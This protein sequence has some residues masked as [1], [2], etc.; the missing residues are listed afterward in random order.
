MEGGKVFN[1]RE[2]K[3]LPCLPLRRTLSFAH[4]ELLN[5]IKDFHS[6][7]DPVK[8]LDVL[9]TGV[10]LVL[11]KD[12]P[13]EKA[14]ESVKRIKENTVDWNEARV[15]SLYE[16]MEWLKP[17]G[18][19]NLEEKC[20]R[21]KQFLVSVYREINEMDLDWLSDTQPEERG[22][23][24]SKLDMLEPWMI[25]YLQCAAEDFNCF[26]FQSDLNRVLHRTGILGKE[27]TLK[28]ASQA[29]KEMFEGMK[30]KFLW[31]CSLVK[32]GTE[33]CISS[34]RVSACRKCPI[35]DACPTSRASKSR[36]EKK[37]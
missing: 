10:F 22:K 25:Y 19:E 17:A 30:N 9:E 23:I 32:H 28:K 31:L 6:I 14:V 1:L 35:G 2:L 29:A 13:Y 3:F 12:T 20:N 5:A 36:D 16:F 15:S 24:L 4:I 18:P 27:S 34:L 21:V 33:V 11:S 7:P 37:D 8:D 26:I